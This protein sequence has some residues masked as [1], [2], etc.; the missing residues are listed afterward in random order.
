MEEDIL[1]QKQIL[2]TDLDGVTKSWVGVLQ[3]LDSKSPQKYENAYNKVLDMGDDIYLLRLI[4]QTGP[5]I[6]DLNPKTAR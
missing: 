2:Y 3:E 1:R 4:S 5:V 6:R